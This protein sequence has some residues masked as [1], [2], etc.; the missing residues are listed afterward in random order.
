MSGRKG[1]ITAQTLLKAYAIGI[2]PMAESRDDPTIYW[3]DPD[4]RGVIPLESFHVPSRL[5]RTVRSDVYSVMI[6]SAFADVIDGCAAPGAGRP[7]SWINKRVRELYIALHRLGHAHSV[8][9]YQHNL[10]VGGLYGVSLGGAFFGESM[11]SRA[12]DASKVALVHLVAR[13]KYGGYVLLDTQFITDH[14]KQFGAIEIPRADY[15]RRLKGALLQRGDFYSLRPGG[16]IS[17]AG[18][19]GVPGGATSGGGAS[20]GIGPSSTGGAVWPA[21][22]RGGMA[23]GT[24]SSV[25]QLT[26]QTS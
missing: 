7:N 25:L 20:S 18:V 13:L 9:V 26:T 10:L 3:I 19:T 23:S 6:N 5:R 11:F 22:S 14:L 24:G 17:G 21:A 16:G 8:E 12:R 2:F 4:K 15:Q 1:E